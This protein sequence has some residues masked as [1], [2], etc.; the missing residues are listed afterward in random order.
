LQQLDYAQQLPSFC[1]RELRMAHAHTPI[2]H[3]ER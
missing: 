1:S 3:K 2:S